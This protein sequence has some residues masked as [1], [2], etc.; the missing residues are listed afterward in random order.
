MEIQTIYNFLKEYEDE[1]DWLPDDARV[2]E[3]S[4]GEFYP[5]D[6]IKTDNFVDPEQFKN[7]DYIYVIENPPKWLEWILKNFQIK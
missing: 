3:D 7:T 5:P 4:F 1:I 6:E 2:F